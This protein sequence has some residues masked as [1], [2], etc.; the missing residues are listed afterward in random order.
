MLLLHSQCY[1]CNQY[2][3]RNDSVMVCVIQSRLC[4]VGIGMF[5]AITLDLLNKLLLDGNHK[6]L[7]AYQSTAVFVMTLILLMQ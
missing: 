3:V 1:N 6:T 2:F 5:I 7:Y 4:V